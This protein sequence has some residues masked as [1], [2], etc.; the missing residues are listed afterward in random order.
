MIGN[1]LPEVDQLSVENLW[2][3]YKFGLRTGAAI[4]WSTVEVP[5]ATSGNYLSL[6]KTIFRAACKS[7]PLTKIHSLEIIGLSFKEEEWIN[8]FGDLE[9]LTTITIRITWL[10]LAFALG[11]NA[12]WGGDREYQSNVRRTPLAFPRATRMI[13]HMVNIDSSLLEAL[14]AVFQIRSNCGIKFQSLEF[15][16]CC[17]KGR[18]RD[19]DII[20][21]LQHLVEE[22]IEIYGMRYLPYYV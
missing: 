5:C 4:G 9:F 8:L 1:R 12:P 6:P 7:L 16:Y 20:Q 10:D 19:E 22:D 17:L 13:L 14:A 18:L 15:I 21:K 2:D 11:K 3:V